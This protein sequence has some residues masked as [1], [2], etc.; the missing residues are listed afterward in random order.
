MLKSNSVHDKSKPNTKSKYPNDP[1]QTMW[2]H[3]TK[4]GDSAAFGHIVEKYQK[5]VFNICYHMLSNTRDVEDAAQEIFIRAYSRLDTYDDTSKFSTWLF[6]IASHYCIDMLR[7][8]QFN[9]VNWDDLSSWYHLPNQNTPQPEEVLIKSEAA[10]EI[11]M[12]LNL[13]PPNYRVAVVLK[14]WYAMSCQEIAETLETTVSAIKSK[15]F[16]A[17]KLMASKSAIAVKTTPQNK[18]STI[19]LSQILP[20]SGYPVMH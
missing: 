15:L 17:R 10:Q 20:A 8:R 2:L 12:L 19:A 6:S 7:K 13:L 18:T 1:E 5:P 9:L 16:R 3:Q 4:N 14:Y 11:H